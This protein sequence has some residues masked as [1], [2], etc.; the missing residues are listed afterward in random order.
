LLDATLFTGLASALLTLDAM[1]LKITSDREKSMADKADAAYRDLRRCV[2]EPSLR[3]IIG[4][5]RGAFRAKGFL[6][7]PE[8]VERLGSYNAAL[9]C[10]TEAD[11]RRGVVLLALGLAFKASAFTSAALYALAGISLASAYGGTPPPPPPPPLPSPSY[12]LPAGLMATALGVL[13]VACLL[14]EWRH[15]ESC[16]RR[17]TRAAKRRLP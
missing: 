8:V 13:L 6:A 17:E 16:F 7:A 3:P 5:R 10:Y 11:G 4:A 12:V 14:Y 9:H 2:L 15:E 1:L